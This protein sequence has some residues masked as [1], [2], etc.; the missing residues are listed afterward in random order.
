[1]SLRARGMERGF[2]GLPK[3]SP[4]NIRRHGFKDEQE[5]MWR[6]FDNGSG[7]DLETCNEKESSEDHDH[8]C[9][10]SLS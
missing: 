3:G 8:L 6:L 9:V 7:L 5:L 4:L 1:M 10:A 2:V